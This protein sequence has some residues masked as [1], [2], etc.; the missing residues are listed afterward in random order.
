M[1]KV[2]A[3]KVSVLGQTFTLTGNQLTELSY[4]LGAQD[5][6]SSCTIGIID[7]DLKVSDIF[8]KWSKEKGG[9]KIPAGLRGSSYDPKTNTGSTN[10]NPEKPSLPGNG[11]GGSTGT[12]N[13]AGKL[14]GLESLP[15]SFSAFLE[16]I[17]WCEN[18][19]YNMGNLA[20][21]VRFGGFTF[22][23]YSR[24][25]DIVYCSGGLCSNAAGAFQF[26]GGDPDQSWE[27]MRSR[28]P[29]ELP[30]SFLPKYQNI[31][32]MLAIKTYASRSDDAYNRIIRGTDSDIS[33]A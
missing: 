32:A 3:A 5:R 7:P 15:L 2:I 28:Y 10:T 9:I 26:I 4:Q 21:N 8:Y 16:T 11:N 33:R 14:E 19:G 13:N 1:S 27:D 24:H 18:R 25:P 12:G 31:G 22:S 17:G 20:Y 6:S 30:G 29:K 23:D